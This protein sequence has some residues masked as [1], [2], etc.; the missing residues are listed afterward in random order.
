MVMTRAIGGIACPSPGGFG[1]DGAGIA[2]LAP[3]AGASF[4][5]LQVHHDGDVGPLTRHLRPIRRIQPL[6]TDPAQGIGPFVQ[7]T[8]GGRPQAGVLRHRARFGAR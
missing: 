1:G 3:E 6:P 8:F 2:Q 5:R 4:Q 7:R